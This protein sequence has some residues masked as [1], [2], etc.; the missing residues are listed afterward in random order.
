MSVTKV[1]RL[2]G[3][4]EPYPEFEAKPKTLIVQRSVW[5]GA[6]FEQ[7]KIDPLTEHVFPVTWDKPGG[8]QGYAVLEIS[9]STEELSSLRDKTAVLEMYSRVQQRPGNQRISLPVPQVMAHDMG[10]Q[11]A[12]S[13]PFVLYTLPFQAGPAINLMPQQGEVLS[14]SQRLAL[15]KQLGKMFNDI[16]NS[17]VDCSPGCIP[18]GKPAMPGSKDTFQYMPLCTQVP[19]TENPSGN[20]PKPTPTGLL[21]RGRFLARSALF[22]YPKDG[23]MAVQSLANMYNEACDPVWEMDDVGMFKD[24][25]FVPVDPGLGFGTIGLNKERNML[26]YIPSSDAIVAPD[27]MA[28]R[29]PIKSAFDEAAGPEF[30]YKAYA[31]HWGFARQLA[32]FALGQIDEIGLRRKCAEG[33][34]VPEEPNS[35]SY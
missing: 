31:T 29:P 22:K 35:Y 17:T 6:K 3:S 32:W 1:P 25:K 33:V 16:L 10:D 7:L 30:V 28:C 20:D 12:L 13:S 24:V 19:Q 5:P 2:N 26:R 14:H 8:P 15:A 27:F 34:D 11:N 18:G 23:F 4:D 9:T 21:L